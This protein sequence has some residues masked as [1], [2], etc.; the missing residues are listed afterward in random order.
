M[1]EN[2]SYPVD[3]QEFSWQYIQQIIDA[4]RPKTKVNKNRI[5]ETLNNYKIGISSSK[6]KVG[7]TVTLYEII[8]DAG[9]R[10]SNSFTLLRTL[11]SKI[12]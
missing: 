9:I 4:L 3:Y 1:E 5:V 7:P 10:I 11:S 8:P 12:T 6:A 2:S